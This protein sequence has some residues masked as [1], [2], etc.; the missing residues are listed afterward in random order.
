[1]DRRKG[2]NV[3]DLKRSLSSLSYEI[4]NWSASRSCSP[5]GKKSKRPSNVDAR[6]LQAHNLSTD[7]AISDFDSI[8]WYE[9]YTP[10]KVSEVSIHKRKLKEVHDEL[11]AML[12]G[13]SD[14]RIL[15]L[16]G[17]SGCCKSTVATLLA[18]ELVPRYRA[19][20]DGRH[21]DIIRYENDTTPYGG[22]HMNNFGEFLSEAKYRIGSNLSLVLVEDIPNVFHTESRNAFQRQLLE[23]LYLPRRSLPPLV[24][25]LTECELENDSG[26]S[27]AYGIDYSWTA[28]SILGREILSHVCLKRVKFNPINATLMRKTLVSI[29]NDNKAQLLQLKKWND[30]DKV[31]DKLIQSTGDVRSGIA[32]LQFWATSTGSALPD[33]RESST[34]Y[35]HAIGKILHGSHDTENDNETINE[36]L[37]TSKGHLSHENFSLGILENYS[38]FN[39]GQ[40][41]ISDACNVTDSLSESNAM[42]VVPESLEFCLRK[43]RHT[44]SGIDQGSHSHGRPKF[45]REWKI[46][47]LQNEFTIESED[48]TNVSMYKYGVPRLFRN[49]ALQFGFYD[50]KI[51]RTRFYKQKALNHYRAKL[52]ADTAPE[53]TQ[54]HNL[55]ADPALDIITRIGGDINLIESQDTEVFE[56]DHKSTARES[57]DQ[58]RRKRDAKLQK[59]QESYVADTD[60]TAPTDTEDEPFED[61]PIVDS[62]G[63]VEAIA[64]STLDDDD[65]IYEALS[66]KLPNPNC[67]RPID[68]SLSDSDLEGL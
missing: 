14:K 25:C 30:K 32:M 50:P 28:E 11:E 66:Q 67:E 68:E 8:P 6:D 9:K 47:K 21:E 61:D 40:F 46:R 17:P 19:S 45:P 16:T 60:L 51:R 29:C 38:S 57:L 63:G 62:D 43:V 3:P 1:M 36:L 10:R 56:D 48:Y 33:V 64:N 44:L 26:N 18:K 31:I 59:L 23:W 2:L 27:A 22:S 65:S 37:S 42:S 20:S 15:L 4:T 49:I 53:L 35:F 12:Q 7:L 39:K 41:N 24:I 5:S 58:L 55:D 13:R 54:P 52:R 34:S